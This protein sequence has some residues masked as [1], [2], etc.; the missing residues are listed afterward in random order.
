MFLNDSDMV[1]VV[2]SEELLMV[3]F[4][5][6]MKGVND[7][8][9]NFLLSIARYCIFRRRNL[10]NNGH[11]TVNLVKLFQYTL[12]HYITYMHVYF[13]QIRNMANVFEKKFLLHNPLITETEN[14]LTFDL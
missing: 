1:S 5:W 9:L 3:G 11:S 10:V 12:K 6:K 14:V 2:S 4:R 7:A 13:C 8:F